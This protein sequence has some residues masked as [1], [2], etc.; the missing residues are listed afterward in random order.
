MAYT[1]LSDALRAAA[2]FLVANPLDAVTRPLRTVS[3]I[4][5]V[6]PAAFS[7]LAK[8]LSYED[9]EELREEMRAKIDQ[10]VNNFA[11]RAE[12]LQKQ[13]D[14]GTNRFI[15][16]H[17]A[18]S[19]GNLSR[20][21]SSL[22]EKDLEHSV[23]LLVNARKVLLLGALG[24]TGIVEYMSYMAN[25]CSDNWHLANRMGASLGG[26]LSGMDS[27]DVLFI[28]TKPPF[29]SNVIKAAKLAHELGVVVIIITDTHACP[30]LEFASISFVVP[31]DSA[32]F[33]SSYVTTLFLI[34]TI[35]GMVVGRS[36]A[37]AQERIA[38]VERHNR[39]MAEVWSE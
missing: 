30:A 36:G 19:Q 23:D 8:A 37:A 25:F 5:G 32:N 20:T 7:R 4:S 13:H 3:R 12:E 18:I 26:S 21:V 22:D 6:S 39:Q 1:D 34:E 35:I 16:T 27:R 10:R 11:A 38:E 29:A 15:D 24:S 14:D 31:A 28:V 2:D 17:F 33:Y 9:F